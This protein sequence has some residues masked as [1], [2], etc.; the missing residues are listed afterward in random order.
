MSDA[1]L[2]YLNDVS[3]KFAGFNKENS[4]F[5]ILGI[6]MDI[7]SSY[8]PGSRFAPSAIRDAAQ[9]IEFYSLR[10]GIDMGE[11]GFNDIGDVA[12]HPS[13]VEENVKRI[14]DVVSYFSEKGKI[15][16]SIGGEHT[17]T[18]GTASGTSADCVIS[19][20]AHLDLRDD[21]LGYKYD[22][23]CVMRRLS[24]KGIKIM[25]IGNRAV[26]KEELEYARKAGVPFITSWDVELLG[27]KEVARKII[28]FTEECKRIYITY[29]MDSID[30]SYAP[31]VATPEPE[32]LKPT[33]ILDIVK[34]IADK[35]IVGFDIVEVS[36]PFDP[37][38]ITSVLAAKIIME[39]SAIIKSKLP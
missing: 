16:V 13:N 24:E 28:N 9:Y 32:G 21:Y 7:T 27:Y 38:G 8:R 15:V 20:D 12:L 35:R 14:S 6:P 5:V 1:R 23:A 22:H 26:S 34:L 17:I 11:V 25:E 30:P 29:D 37:S 36:P 3:R 4:P 10:T 33:T 2:L 39:T 18:V 19:F 31:G